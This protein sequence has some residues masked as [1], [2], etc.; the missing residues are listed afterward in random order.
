MLSLIAVIFASLAILLSLF[1]FFQFKKQNSSEI[2]SA[3]LYTLF[4][5][6]RK[7]V[8]QIRVSVN[9]QVLDLS[10]QMNTHLNQNTEFMN[11]THQGY[12]TS[13]GQVQRSLGELQQVTQ[14][15]L[16]VGKDISSLQNLLKSPKMRGGIGEFL[17]SELLRQILP[18]DYFTLQYSFRDGKKVDAIVRLGQ[19]FVCVDAKFPYE[20]FKR[21]MESSLEE[22]VKQA[23]KNFISDV[24]KHIDDIANKYILPQEG[25]YDFAL[26]YI[27]AENIYYEIIIKDDNQ[28]ESIAEYAA[29]KHVFPVSPNSFY[30]YLQAIAHGLKG[31]KIERSAQMILQGLT[32]IENDFRKLLDEFE[33]VGTH[34]KNSQTAYDRAI[35]N[36]EKLHSKLMVL[37]HDQAQLS[38]PNS[39]NAVL[40]DK[41]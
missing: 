20:N 16:E 7:E 27:P 26:M 36:F 40:I 13:V 15:M 22:D 32:Q 5:D 39:E 1:F 2:K 18:E 9:Q 3:D 33:K 21:I 11:Q 28:T 4:N 37:S 10:R 25:T 24:K 29:K 17:L 14:S 12:T 23:K 30:A 41:T 19:A 31:M 6:F 38:V 35:R 34:I 8:E